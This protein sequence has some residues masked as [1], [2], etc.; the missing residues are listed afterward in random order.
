MLSKPGLLR[1]RQRLWKTIAQSA[2]YSVTANPVDARALVPSIDL[3]ADHLYPATSWANRLASPT[4]GM[5][6]NKT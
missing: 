6:L 4:R 5:L 1:R 3:L 2:D